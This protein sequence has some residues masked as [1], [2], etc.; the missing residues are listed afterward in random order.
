MMKR[1][2]IFR[3]EQLEKKSVLQAGA[4]RIVFG[5]APLPANIGPHDTVHRILLVAPEERTAGLDSHLN[6]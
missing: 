6:R 3:L 1:K 2:V 5:D 4:H